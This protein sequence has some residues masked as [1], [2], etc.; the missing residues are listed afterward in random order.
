MSLLLQLKQFI[1]L[2]SQLNKEYGETIMKYIQEN[3]QLIEA[4]FELFK[5]CSTEN[6]GKVLTDFITLL[7]QNQN[8][9]T[10]NDTKEVKTTQ[11]K[12]SE[13]KRKKSLKKILRLHDDLNEMKENGDGT[14]S[15]EIKQ[16]E[17]KLRI[18]VA[19]FKCTYHDN[20]LD[21]I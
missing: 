4:A 11:S 19:E 16:M 13:R 9:S 20:P 10:I 17:K 2:L 7:Q 21:Y 18:L 5:G 15:A 3:P 1:P 14:H 8:D 6:L 12:E